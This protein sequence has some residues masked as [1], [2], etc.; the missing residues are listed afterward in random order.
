MRHESDA[1]GWPLPELIPPP[2]RIPLA[3]FLSK[4]PDALDGSVEAIVLFGSLAA[5]DFD[6][7][8]SD[9]DLIVAISSDVSDEALESLRRMHDELSLAHPQWEG[10]FDVAYIS[11]LGLQTF[12][13]RDHPLAVISRG[14]PIHR[15]ST[16]EGW[17]MNWHVAREAGVSLLGPPPRELIAATTTAEFVAAIR[18]HMLWL[19]AKA[20]SSN[21]PELQAYAIVTA[22]RALYSWSTG[23]QSSKEAAAVWAEQRYPEWSQPIRGAR[24][25][26]G[27]AAGRR[28]LAQSPIPA[29]IEFVEFATREVSQTPRGSILESS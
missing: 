25:W 9:I 29:G 27:T 6:V 10:R 16:D 1:T 15:T 4:A 13:E 14:E 28:P 24:E 17:I 23:T 7:R 8:T 21:A 11:T 12:K 26:R 3:D 22:C 18:T 5:G 2:V 20:A 19:H